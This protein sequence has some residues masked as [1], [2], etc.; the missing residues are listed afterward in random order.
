MK[1]IL[2]FSSVLLLGLTFN[3]L[4]H[5]TAS[6][7]PVNINQA[8]ATELATLKGIGVK[9]AAA[10]VSY[11]EQHGNFKSVDDLAHVRGISNKMLQKI[12]KENPGKL[13][14]KHSQ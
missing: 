6:H 2:V 9:K 11:R 1:K 13:S 12:E 8:T 14:F 10:I 3:S 5:Q 7:S 4:A